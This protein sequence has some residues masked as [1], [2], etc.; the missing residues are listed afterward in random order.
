MLFTTVMVG[1]V[2][3]GVERGEG[4]AAGRVG[5]GFAREACGGFPV[6]YNIQ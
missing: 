4:E 6:V 2:S 5:K 3:D 1:V